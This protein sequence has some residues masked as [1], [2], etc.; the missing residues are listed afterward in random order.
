MG[1]I[2]SVHNPLLLTGS[3]WWRRPC[4]AARA[5]VSAGA[6]YRRRWPDQ[7]RRG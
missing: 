5:G 7:L 6:P 3:S 2:E 4:A 1:P